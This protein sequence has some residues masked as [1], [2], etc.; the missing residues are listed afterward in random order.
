MESPPRSFQFHLMTALFLM[1][2]LGALTP[3]LLRAFRVSVADGAATFY[4][5][6][7]PIVM[8]AFE[9][10]AWLQRRAAPDARYERPTQAAHRTLGTLLYFALELLL[11]GLWA[12]C[13]AKCLPL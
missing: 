5:S 12:I 9:L 6:A 11:I 13:V 10:E 3:V 7:L 1:L 2:A 4:A 8:I